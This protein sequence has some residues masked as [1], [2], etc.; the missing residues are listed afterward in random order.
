MPAR[1]PQDCDLQLAAAFRT[2][3]LEAVVALYEAGATFAPQPGQAVTGHA[4]IRAAVQQFL[5]MQPDLQ[6]QV[7]S[8]T[9]AG[10]LALLCSAW[11]LTGTGPDGKSM[12]MSGHG[13]E[14]VRRQADGTW[15]FVLDN[16]YASA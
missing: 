6:I 11:T 5:A 13:A 12:S 3:D 7:T 2:R 1:T 10:D 15:R 4:A 8:I 14:V 16:P 9:T